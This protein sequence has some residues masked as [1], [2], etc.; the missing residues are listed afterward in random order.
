MVVHYSST[1]VGAPYSITST[2][3]NRYRISSFL[4]TRSPSFRL[5]L[6]LLFVNFLLRYIAV[7]HDSHIQVWRTP[8][9]LIREFA[10]FVL[11]RE[12]TGHHDQVVSIE[13]SLD[14]KFVRLSIVSNKIRLTAGHYRCFI[15]TSRDMTARLFTLDPLEGFRPKTFAGHRDVVLG[16]YFASDGRQVSGRA[17]A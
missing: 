15:T 17:S 10:P 6:P 3:K 11:H 12:Y 14:S 5:H 1:S 9:H 4:P 7:T 2:S 13:W 16:A 8:N